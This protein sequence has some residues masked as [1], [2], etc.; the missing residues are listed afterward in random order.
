[1]A[2]IS[3]SSAVP[4]WPGVSFFDKIQSAPYS[5]IVVWLFEAC[6][7]VLESKWRTNQTDFQ[8]DFSWLK[9]NSK[10]VANFWEFLWFPKNVE[11]FWRFFE[12]FFEFCNFLKRFLWDFYR[13]SQKY[14]KN[15]NIFWKIATIFE[16][17][18]SQE[19]SHWKS[20]SL[21]LHLDSKT[22]IHASNNHT[23][24]LE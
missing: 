21:V 15:L 8:C 13:K 18:L 12:E 22:V 24:I 5:K 11:L 14:L 16:L 9:N 23:T 20:V 1:M 6:I 19:K 3:T 10:I 4:N 17:L 7:T 2:L